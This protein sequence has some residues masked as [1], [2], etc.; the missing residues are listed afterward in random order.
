[1]SAHGLTVG[2]PAGGRSLTPFTAHC[3]PFPT[4]SHPKGIA[5]YAPS[6]RGQLDDDLVHFRQNGRR[7]LERSISD[8]GLSRDG[9]SCVWPSRAVDS[10]ESRGRYKIVASCR[11]RLDQARSY[12]S[13]KLALTETSV[14]PLTPRQTT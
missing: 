1:M 11:C 9:L 7:G 5:K 4:S 13:F 2:V 8:L 12:K 14:E 3:N 10:A 6:R